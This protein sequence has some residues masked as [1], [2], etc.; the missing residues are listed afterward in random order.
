M[1]LNS[2][3]PRCE[4][5]YTEWR[6]DVPEISAHWKAHDNKYPQKIVMS[7]EQRSAFMRMRNVSRD[8]GHEIHDTHFMGV[9]IEEVTGV[10]GYLVAVD[11][12]QVPL[13]V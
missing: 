11:G 9:A 5:S 2:C 10:P 3:A 8:P 12:G 1:P 7:P 4:S 13:D 6:T